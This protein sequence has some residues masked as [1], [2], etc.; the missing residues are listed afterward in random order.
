[1][2]CKSCI[3][4]HHRIREPTNRQPKANQPA[5]NLHAVRYQMHRL[6]WMTGASNRSPQASRLRIVGS[7]ANTVALCMQRTAL[8]SCMTTPLPKCPLASQPRQSTS[9]PAQQQYA[10]KTPTA[11]LPMVVHKHQPTS[12]PLQPHR[13]YRASLILR[14]GTAHP[15]L[16]IDARRWQV[17]LNANNERRLVTHRAN[18]VLQIHH[19]I[20]RPTNCS[21]S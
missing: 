1:M 5:H 14:R 20:C 15:H 13:T 17:T 8:C 4:E 11:Q 18:H 6:R 2:S 7:P 19:R 16:T 9:Q 12:H 3:A 21:E 10:C